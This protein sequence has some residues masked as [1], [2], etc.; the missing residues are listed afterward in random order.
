MRIPFA[1][2]LLSFAVL[3][4]ACT[5]SGTEPADTKELDTARTQW[6]TQLPAAYRVTWKQSCFC[7]TDLLRP[8]RI[9]VQAGQ[10][11]SA[12]YVDDQQPVASTTRGV[13]LTV[14]G[15]FDKIHAAITEHAAEVD[16]RFD[17]TR[18][19]PASVFVDY[20]KQ[21]ADEEFSV[22]LSDL[23]AGLN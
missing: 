23:T 19:Y 18:G 6:T 1:C 11:V 13:L 17:P 21:T 4:T 7:G 3:G 14:D 16:V 8:I 5:S 20:S 15:L 22:Q 2:L 12:V 9:S 10:I